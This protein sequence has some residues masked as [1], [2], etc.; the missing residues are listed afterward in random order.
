M[1]ATRRSGRPWSARLRE[2]RIISRAALDARRPLL[3]QIIPMRRC[4]L[5]CG[6][7]NEY[8]HASP[9]V[10]AEVMFARID[11]LATMG[12][13]VVTISGGEPLLH[14]ELEAIIR[15]IHDRGMVVTLIT[16]GVLLGRDRIQT[17]NAA[18]L[19]RLQISIDNLKPDEVSKKSLMVL[20]RKLVMLAEH[21][22]FDVNVNSVL[23]SG[24]K[25]PEDAL[26]IAR[27]AR[28]LGFTATMG[29]IHDGDG[30]LKSL[31]GRAREV[32]D[33][34]QHLTRWSITRLN[35]SFQ[36]RLA[37]GRPNDWRCRAGSRYL[38]VCEDGLVHYCS[39]RRGTPG[40][41]L[42][43]YTLTHRRE[44]HVVQKTCSPYCTIACV[45]Q[46]SSFDHWR[47]VQRPI[48]ARSAPSLPGTRAG[49]ESSPHRIGAG[50]A[51]GVQ[52]PRVARAPADSR[53]RPRRWRPVLHGGHQGSAGTAAGRARIHCAM[54]CPAGSM[55]CAAITARASPRAPC[56]A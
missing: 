7:C 14:P 45:H 23:G 35:R 42:V 1:A 36:N 2:L 15:H 54:T 53:T 5:A 52:G 55:P 43:R 25:Q 3:V 22:M 17:L 20:D 44:A 50:V 41:P 51:A 13:A 11:L 9:P 37:E 47:G 8:D 48:K 18:R 16:N 34:F 39:Q 19:D 12:T 38:Y 10:P 32:H 6:Y 31:V 28:E 30:H 27:R 24:V 29:I 40:I 46:A 21:A 33:A 56:C 26:V 49:A 4:N